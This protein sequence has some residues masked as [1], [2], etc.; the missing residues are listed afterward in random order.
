MGFLTQLIS[1]DTRFPRWSRQDFA[2]LRL[3]YAALV[4]PTNRRERRHM[5]YHT[6]SK[7][8]WA[9]WTTCTIERAHLVAHDWGAAAGWALAALHPER[10]NR[11]VALSVGHPATFWQSGLDQREKSWYMLLFQFRGTAEELLTRDDWQ[12][13]RDWVRHHPEA[14][15][16][17]KGL[18]RPGA[19]TA[20]LN[21]YRA[22]VAPEM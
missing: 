14:E 8:S 6:F 1:G 18:Q 13:F 9:C 22:N 19:L 12:L 17:I 4:I 11:L 21:W 2:L 15:H 16:W 10:V 3:T 7:T 20:A 5:H